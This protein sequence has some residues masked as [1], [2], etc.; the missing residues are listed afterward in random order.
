MLKATIPMTADGLCRKDF[1]GFLVFFDNLS[2]RFTATHPSST[3]FSVGACS[4]NSAV[5]DS[6]AN[7]VKDLD[8][9]FLS[10]EP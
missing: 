7:E 3:L 8:V 1:I 10:M 4:F 6:Q 5:T 2:R 9:E